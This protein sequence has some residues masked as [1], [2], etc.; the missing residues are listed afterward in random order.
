ML[1]M[2]MSNCLA[3]PETGV[4]AALAWASALCCL[5]CSACARVFLRQTRR[6]GRTSVVG[7]GQCRGSSAGTVSP[8][9]L[10][11]W[12]LASGRRIFALITSTC[13]TENTWRFLFARIHSGDAFCFCCP[14]HKKLA[15]QASKPHSL[16]SLTSSCL[17]VVDSR[18]AGRVPSV[19]VWARGNWVG[20]LPHRT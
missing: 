16:V 12:S 6:S 17:S 9:R 14:R 20:R 2:G 4:L 15:K 13:K 3:R 5:Q 7:H 18:D 8:L 10:H 11:C 1:R 19:A